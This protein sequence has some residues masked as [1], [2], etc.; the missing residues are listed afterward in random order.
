MTALLK[1][2]DQRRHVRDVL[3]CAGRDFGPLATKG[4]KIF[5]ERFDVL[6]GVLVE[7]LTSLLGLGDDTIIYIG[8]IHHLRHAETL[9]FEVSA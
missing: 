9:E 8:D 5:P 6:C 7:R 3:R 2:A 1:F 4:V